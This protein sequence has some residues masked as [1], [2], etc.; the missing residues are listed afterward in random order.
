MH[1][2]GWGYRPDEGYHLPL[3]T[4]LSRVTSPTMATGMTRGTS[5]PLATDLSRGYR[6]PQPQARLGGPPPPAKGLIRGYSPSPPPMKG[7]GT[8]DQG[9]LPPPPPPQTVNCDYGLRVSFLHSFT[10]SKLSVSLLSRYQNIV[11]T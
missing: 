8:I 9:L 2:R 4:D 1:L 10:N 11:L 7:P 3:A 6:S 5:P